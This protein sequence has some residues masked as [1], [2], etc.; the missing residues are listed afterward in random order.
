MGTKKD[1]KDIEDDDGGCQVRKFLFCSL[2]QNKLQQSRYH[3]IC[4]LHLQWDGKQAIE[5][6]FVLEPIF[7]LKYPAKSLIVHLLQAN[8]HS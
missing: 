7:F 1:I 8:K 2:R 4:S 3:S 6:G 5:D